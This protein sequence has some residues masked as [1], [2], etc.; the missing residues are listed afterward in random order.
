MS[1]IEKKVRQ[2]ALEMSHQ[3]NR[4]F[5]LTGHTK[6][7]NLRMTQNDIYGM[8]FEKE[9]LQ[10][11]VPKWEPLVKEVKKYNEQ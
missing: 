7:G 3:E 10:C 11:V 8:R 2:A 9:C 1:S 5:E 6:F 4:H